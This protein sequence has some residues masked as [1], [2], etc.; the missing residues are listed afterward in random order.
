MMSSIN[1]VSMIC[2]RL[3]KISLENTIFGP[4]KIPL[5]PLI[6]LEPNL[7]ILVKL[8]TYASNQMIH[9]DDRKCYILLNHY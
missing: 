6:D 4:N 7:M 5:K 2:T 9:L 1:K 8:S 3:Y